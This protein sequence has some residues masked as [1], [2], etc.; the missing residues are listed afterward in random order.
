MKAR[1]RWL[2]NDFHETFKETIVPI[3]QKFYKKRDED[4]TSHLFD[5][6]DNNSDKTFHSDKDILIKL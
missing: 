6:A 5:M 4:E 2:N 3:L 1:L